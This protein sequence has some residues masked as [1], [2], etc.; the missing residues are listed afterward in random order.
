MADFDAFHTSPSLFAS[1]APCG[2]LVDADGPAW[3]PACDP[4][5]QQSITAGLRA[6]VAEDGGG[7][8]S[9]NDDQ[10]THEGL[11][12]HYCWVRLRLNDIPTWN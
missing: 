12:C 10:I 1:I 4:E 3:C 7:C 9:C 6:C 5:V 2:C 8:L 11:Y